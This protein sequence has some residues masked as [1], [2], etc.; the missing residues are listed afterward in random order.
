MYFD[1]PK[2]VLQSV[3]ASHVKDFNP[4]SRMAALSREKRGWEDT[5]HHRGRSENVLEREC[6]SIFKSTDSMCEYLL[7]RVN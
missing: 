1:V 7:Q 4:C 2:D 3:E 6:A 5:E